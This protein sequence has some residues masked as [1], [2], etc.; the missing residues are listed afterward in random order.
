MRTL[1]PLIIGL[2]ASLFTLGIQSCEQEET[3]DRRPD[4][5]PFEISSWEEHIVKPLREGITPQQYLVVEDKSKKPFYTQTK[6]MKGKEHP[7]GMKETIADSKDWTITTLLRPDSTPLMIKKTYKQTGRTKSQIEHSLTFHH[8][9]KTATILAASVAYTWKS[10]S[11]ETNTLQLEYNGLFG[12]DS[13]KAHKKYFSLKQSDL[14]WEFQNKDKTLRWEE[15]L[16][17]TPLRRFFDTMED[18]IKGTELE[19]KTN[20]DTTISHEENIT[21]LKQ[22]NWVDKQ[23]EISTKLRV[24]GN[25]IQTTITMQDDTVSV[26]GYKFRTQEKYPDTTTKEIPFQIAILYTKDSNNPALTLNADVF[27]DYNFVKSYTGFTPQKPSKG[28]EGKTVNKKLIYTV[29]LNIRGEKDTTW[30]ETATI[31]FL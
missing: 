18:V 23:G 11:T 20:N 24:N 2:L 6:Y 21:F 3:S 17:K 19:P 5:K 29:A 10:N 12:L 28:S 25:F 14:S 22:Y 27:N 16:G 26:N 13:S 31:P 1:Q 15:A 8:S 7:N 4:Y 9:S 30:Q